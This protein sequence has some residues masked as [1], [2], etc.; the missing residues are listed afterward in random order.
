[1]NQ[2]I[3]KAAGFSEEVEL[4]N[5]KKCPICKEDIDEKKLR[6]Q[7]SKDEYLISGMC[8]ACQD[9]LFGED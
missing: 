2:D 8:Q 5:Q 1:M 4:V 7:I 3:M 9:E 6:N